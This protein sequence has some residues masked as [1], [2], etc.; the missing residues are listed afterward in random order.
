MIGGNATCSNETVFFT[1]ITRGATGHSHIWSSDEYIGST[2]QELPVDSMNYGQQ[3]MSSRVVPTTTVI[4][5]GV[6]DENDGTQML[7]SRLRILAMSSSSNHSVTCKHGINHE[8]MMTV[9]FH[10]YGE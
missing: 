9:N 10:V 1:C 3:E 6:Q 7:T 4:V 2:G 5:M 8:E